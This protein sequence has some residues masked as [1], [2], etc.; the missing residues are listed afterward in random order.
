MTS[1]T[2]HPHGPPGLPFLSVIPERVLEVVAS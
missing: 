2:C 1:V